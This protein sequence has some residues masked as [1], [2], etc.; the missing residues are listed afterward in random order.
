M[1]REMTP[2]T[3]PRK[4][5]AGTNQ[6]YDRPTWESKVTTCGLITYPRTPERS[7]ETS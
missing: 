7:I 3:A 5:G 4:N 1:E 6:R 2:R